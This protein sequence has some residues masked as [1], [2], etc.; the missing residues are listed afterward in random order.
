MPY[1]RRAKKHFSEKVFRIATTRDIV[2][3]NKVV[4]LAD[5]WSLLIT[6]N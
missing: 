2:K 3:L 6:E 5:T 4:K 1:V